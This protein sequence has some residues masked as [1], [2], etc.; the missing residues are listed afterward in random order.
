VI[1]RQ[2]HG[3]ATERSDVPSSNTLHGRSLLIARVTWIAVSVLA[4]GL[5]V[6]SAPAVFGQYSTV[7]AEANCNFWRLEPE[8]MPA[9]REL[10]LSLATYAACMFASDAIYTLGFSGIGALIFWRRSNDWMALLASL[11]LILFGVDA[12]NILL[13]D[14]PG[15]RFIVTFITYLGNVLFVI[16]FFLFPNGLFVPRW[17]RVL[18]A[19][20]AAY[21]LP[22]LFFSDSPLSGQTW[23]DLIDTFLTLGL[24]GSLVFAQIFRYVRVSGPVE[25]QQTRWVVFG[26]TVAVVALVGTYVVGVTF[27]STL[28]T[29]GGVS[30]VLFLLVSA[31]VINFSFLL[32]PLSI[33]I[34]ILRYRLWD[35]D[36]IINRTLVYGSLTTVLAAVFAI[37][38]TMLLPLL[39]RSILGE[40]DPSLN[41]VIAALII[42]VIFEPLRRRIKVGVNRLTD[43]LAG[44]AGTNESPR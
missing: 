29:P 23:P 2:A 28:L 27:R 18:A 35:I 10:N 11:T 7:C 31:T 14:Y 41:A 8:D 37:T 40:D 39:V 36:I 43:W 17:T 32:V 44:G 13:Q 30:H 1:S 4:L 15:W 34:A 26:L 24:F 9:L 21:Q 20:W 42:A 12:P 22:Y 16:S 5:F 25:R 19:I 3:G 6:V 38:D 33:G